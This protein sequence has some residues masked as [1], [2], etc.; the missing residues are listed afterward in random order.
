MANMAEESKMETEEDDL[1]INL[2]F[3]KVCLIIVSDNYQDVPANLKIFDDA[4]TE[5]AVVDILCREH[6]NS[7][8]TTLY[9]SYQY[10]G[11]W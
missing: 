4:K 11:G 10:L 2:F 6:L 3:F 9:V 1:V 5:E 7:F 8:T